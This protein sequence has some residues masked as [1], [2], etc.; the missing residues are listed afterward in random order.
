MYLKLT[1]DDTASFY[2]NESMNAES[3]ECYF[4]F[5]PCHFPRDKDVSFCFMGDI[6]DDLRSTFDQRFGIDMDKDVSTLQF[7]LYQDGNIGSCS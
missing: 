1:N 6:T 5:N 3:K 2:N 4:K 7:Y